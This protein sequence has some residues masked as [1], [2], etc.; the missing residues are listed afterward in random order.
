MEHVRKLRSYLSRHRRLTITV[1]VAM[2]LALGGGVA[3]AAIGGNQSSATATV[4]PTTATAPPTSGNPSS[5]ASGIRRGHIV[6]GTV[7]GISG[8]VWT[9]K[10]RAGAS[11]AVQITNTTK[12]GNKSGPSASTSFAVGDQVRVTGRLTATSTFVATRVVAISSS[13]TGTSAP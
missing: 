2:V 7:T 8:N 12:F 1:G 5:A 10:T 13:T 4:S 3:Y 9:V 6:R 11:V